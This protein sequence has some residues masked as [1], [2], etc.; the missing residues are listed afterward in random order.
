[1]KHLIRY[2]SIF[3]ILLLHA[4][5]STDNAS[6]NYQYLEE[7]TMS[8]LQAGYREGTFTIEQV[9]ADYLQR[10][11]D[12]DKKG[13]KLNSIIF[14][15]P[16]ARETARELDQEWKEGKYRGPLHGIPVI[17]KDNINTSDMPTTAGATV[18]RNSFPPDDSF[19]TKKLRDA[20]AVILGKAN[21]SEWANFRADMSSSGWSGVLGQTKN[22]Y[23]L[24]RNPCGSSSGSGVAASANLCTIAIGT[25]TNGSIVCPSNNNGLVGLKPTVGLVSRSGI[26]PISFTQDTAGPMGR[27]VTDVALC[28]GAL[29]GVDSTDSKTLASYGQALSDYTPHL[30]K[31]GLKGKRIGLLK[32]NMGYHARVDSLIKKAIADIKAQGAEVVELDFRMDREAGSASF[33]VLLYEFKDGLEK[34]F[35][36]LGEKAPVRNLGELMEFNKKDSIELRWFDQQLLKMAHEK[37][38][39]TDKDYQEALAKMLK[40]TRADGID[41][42][43][44]D[45]KLDALMAP[46]G[47]PAWKTDLINGD[48]FL[49]SSSSL[50]AIAGY[51]S[52]TVPM[53]FVEELPVGVSFMASAWQEPKLIEIAYAYEQATRHRQ[54]PRYIS[55]N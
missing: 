32:N 24:D 51:P 13:P 33:T 18:L 45:Y 34:Y 6:P 20:G 30:K 4:C 35:M 38:P 41:K 15:N 28:L 9:V 37:G 19:I 25:E 40:A 16:K 5:E 46:T 17:L 29:V 49:G 52:I 11:E 8:D 1:M 55:G 42:L 3:V 22:P 54:A 47:S 36:S 31:D 27:T 2:V 53:G 44:T 50:A 21:L 43:L 10:I 39:L 48:H 14:I 12:L 26:I 7:I 23:V